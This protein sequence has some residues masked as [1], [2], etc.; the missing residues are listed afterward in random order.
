MDIEQTKSWIDAGRLD[1][2]ESAWMEALERGEA[3]EEM[4][5]VLDA[6]V[7]ADQLDAAE[8]LG[9]ALL[10]QR[11]E[12]RDVDEAAATARAVVSA[13]PVS[14]ELRAQAGEVYRR[15]HGGHEHFDTMLQASGLLSGQ[16]PRRAFRTLDVCLAIRPGDYLVNRFDAQVVRVEGYNDALGEFELSDPSGAARRMEPKKLADEFG[17]AGENDFRVLYRFQRERLSDLLQDDPAAV[18]VGVCM[19]SGGEVDSDELKDRLVPECL[20]PDDWSGWWS[21]ARSAAKRSEQLSIEGRNPVTIAW[22]PQGRTLEQELAD[23]QADTPQE[24]VALLRRYAREA[25]QRRVAPDPDFYV[26]LLD[27]LA[28]QAERFAGRRPTDALVASLGIAEATE[29]GFAPPARE[30]P[31]PAEIL[32]APDDPAAVIADLDD[33]SFW[34]AALD[35]LASRDDAAEHLARLLTRAPVDVLDDVAARVIAA[36]RSDALTA[37]CEE[38]AADSLANLDFAFWLW[39]GP[40]VDVPQAPPPVD[41][42]SRLL[43]VLETVDR[44]WQ[45]DS[46]RRKDV[47]QRIR[48]AL[49]ASD[50]A[51]YRAVLDD[52]DEGVAATLKRRIER[53][54]GLAEAV[55]GEMLDLLRERFHSLFFVARVDPWDDESTVWTTREAM[56]ARQAELKE[57][58]EVTLPANARA[59]GAAAEL[60]DLSENSE[61]KFA[62]EERRRL[63]GRQAQLQDELARARVIEPDDVSSD[64]VGIGSTVTLRRPDDDERVELTFLGP[65]DTDVQRRVYSYRSALARSLMGRSVGE[66]VDLKLDGD[67]ATWEIVGLASAVE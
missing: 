11:C 2:V 24:R 58:V 18:L 30:H 57:L 42:L 35:A 13:V 23:A 20:P 8:T 6:L 31:S 46:D 38:A 43:G 3:P 36:G 21:R 51:A 17:P 12:D 45:M 44:E 34:P 32:A 65:W 26:P 66:Q 48:N 4:A 33:P 59:I 1:E 25:S 37:A 64:S 28:A 40:A 41:R 49:S 63:Q 50:F 15:I 14:D 52:V 55:R 67:E 62:Q 61:W 39:R 56:E 29:A 54:D 9:W 22:H 19:S 27:E 7:E 53:T 47:R 10:E 16:S 5:G 60:G